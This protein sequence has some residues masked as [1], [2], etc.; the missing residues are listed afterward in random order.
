[1]PET[2]SVK[3]ESCKFGIPVDA[4]ERVLLCD[5]PDLKSYGKN[6]K[7]GRRFSCGYG[8]GDGMVIIHKTTSM[9]PTTTMGI[10]K[11]AKITYAS[12]GRNIT[13]REFM[14]SP[15]DYKETLKLLSVAGN[16]EAGF[17]ERFEAATNLLDVLLGAAGVKWSDLVSDFEEEGQLWNI[18]MP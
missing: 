15:Q 10:L 2:N 6:V 8:V 12:S 7:H 9:L 1:V 14:I 17:V 3:C 11:S 4:N 18:S 13:Q 16:K 5:N